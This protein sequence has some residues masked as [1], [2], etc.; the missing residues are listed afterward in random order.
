MGILDKDTIEL[1]IVLFWWIC[2]FSLACSMGLNAYLMNQLKMK[3][4]NE[5]RKLGYPSLFWGNFG[6][7]ELL[8]YTAKGEYKDSL[9]E[10]LVAVFGKARIALFSM[11]TSMCLFFL[12]ILLAEYSK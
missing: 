12:G 8:I 4:P 3:H 10:K 7:V 5:Y 11:L 2:A 6:Y 9:D 1:F